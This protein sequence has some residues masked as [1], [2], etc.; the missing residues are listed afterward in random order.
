MIHRCQ[1]TSRRSDLR[2]SCLLVNILLG[3]HHQPSLSMKASKDLHCVLF[4]KG[5][6]SIAIY[7][8]YNEPWTISVWTPGGHSNKQD[9]D[10]W[11]HKNQVIGLGKRW[12]A[13]RDPN[14]SPPRLSR[15]SSLGEEMLQQANEGLRADR[16]CSISRLYCVSRH[17]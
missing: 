16:E 7:G 5:F 3:V 2:S 1:T 14:V 9:L 17:I 8:G 4:S 13:C 15:K 11:T 12:L 6:A 10:M